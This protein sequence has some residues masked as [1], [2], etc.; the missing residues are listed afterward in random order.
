MPDLTGDLAA[1]LTAALLA[2]PWTD[3]P[4]S[5]HGE[6]RYDASC[7]VCQGD[8]DRLAPWIVRFMEPEAL[9]LEVDRFHQQGEKAAALREAADAWEA[10]GKP[11]EPSPIAVWLRARAN[12]L[13]QPTATGKESFPLRDRIDA[14]LQAAD[15][16]A[17]LQSPD[18][19]ARFTDAVM[20]E[21]EGLPNRGYCEHC[22][23]GDCTPTAA[24]WDE[25]HQHAKQAERELKQTRAAVRMLAERWLG[26][27]FQRAYGDG[28]LAVLDNP[29]G[30]L[31]MRAAL[32]RPDEAALPKLCPIG[33]RP[34]RPHTWTA[35]GSLGGDV[36]VVTTTGFLNPRIKTARVVPAASK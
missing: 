10:L 31:R 24:Q 29:E 25:Q 16:W 35:A 27:D 5:A 6:H 19:R 13:D 3:S 21:I 23:R 14:A 28:L 34:H 11:G 22:G 8:V 17:Q 18:D 9:A 32:D 4:R 30:Y 20:A 7:A 2:E 12:Q 26:P 36:L 15:A 33:Y 1:R